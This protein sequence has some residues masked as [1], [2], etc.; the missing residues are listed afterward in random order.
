M[1]LVCVAELDVINKRN[2]EQLP[3]FRKLVEDARFQT[4]SRNA[5]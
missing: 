3:K 1:T 5:R 2:T 4:R